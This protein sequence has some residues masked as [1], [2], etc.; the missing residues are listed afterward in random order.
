MPAQ[1]ASNCPALVPPPRLVLASSSPYRRALLERFGAPFVSHAPD[2]DES[3][4]AGESPWHLVRRLA[5]AKA[6]ALTH[7][8]PQALIIGSD[9]V[10]VID[11]CALGKPGSEQNAIAQLQ[12]ASGRA[13]R[14]LTSLC[15]LDVGRGSHELAVI[16]SDV[17]F[18]RLSL[19]Q[20]ENYV[21]RERP[22]DCAGSFKCEGLG[23]ALFE[24]VSA[25]DPTALIGLPLIALAAMLSR[26]GFD[27]LADSP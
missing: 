4:H 16:A 15:L 24:A 1:P 11:G 27:V 3:A 9:Q 26:A 10:A 18:R 21:R 5:L 2:L 25:D 6:L 8:H 20:I 23:I 19:Q 13:V 12:Q 22:L 7:I 14:F 17:R